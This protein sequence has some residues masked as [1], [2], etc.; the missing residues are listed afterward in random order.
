MTLPRQEPHT[1]QMFVLVQT[2]TLPGHHSV[3]GLQ[4]AG[5]LQSRSNTAL[6][7]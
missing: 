5:E 7:S 1:L 3:A 4:L 6:T 2:T